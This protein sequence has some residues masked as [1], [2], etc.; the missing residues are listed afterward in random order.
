LARKYRL[1]LVRKVG[2][3]LMTV[4]LK[5]G[6]GPM[7]TRLLTVR[8][9][10]TGR[11][12]TTP[13]NLVRRDDAWCLVAPYGEVSWVH[14]ARAAG[15][16]TLGKGRESRL[17]RIEELPAREAAPVLADYYRQNAITRPY[18]DAHPDDG[19]SWVRETTH[20]PVFRLSEPQVQAVSSK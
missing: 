1:T 8:G 4:A 9:R 6:F 17:H 15:E 2:N 3:V 14:N 10:K 18:F 19:E 16:V 20:H 13:V 5:A 11:E 12:Y 7:N